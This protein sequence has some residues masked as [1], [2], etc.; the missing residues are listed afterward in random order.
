MGNS[1]SQNTNSSNNNL[2]EFILK[3]DTY[4]ANYITNQ[5]VTSSTR[6][7]DLNYCDDLIIMTSNTLAEKLSS[8]E[9]DYLAQRT[10]K[11]N[12]INSMES[13]KI[14]YLNKKDLNDLDVQNKTKKRRLCIGIARFYVKIGQLYSAIL[15]TINPVYSYIDSNNKQI[16]YTL[17]DKRKKKMSPNLVYHSTQ[18]NF[19]NNRI[20]TLLNGEDFSEE[21]EQNNQDVTVNP[22]I[23]R[24]NY[25]DGRSTKFLEQIGMVEFEKLFFD[26]YNYDLGI[27]DKMSD[28]MKVDYK[29]ALTEFYKA[30]T[31]DTNKMPDNIKQ[32]KDIPL[33]AFHD[34]PNCKEEN[35][36]YKQKYK[37]KLTDQLFKKYALHLKEMYN[38][39]QK[40]N[41]ELLEILKKV[42]SIIKNSSS[43][44]ESVIINPNLNYIELEK[45]IKEA[46]NT[47]LKLYTDCE[48]DFYKGFEILQE[49]V[50]NQ[51]NVQVQE[52]LTNLKKTSIFT[53]P[54]NNVVD[55]PY[56]EQPYVE[57]PY[58]EQPYVEQPYVEQPYIEEK[59]YIENNYYKDSNNLNYRNLYE[60]KRKELDNLKFQKAY[61]ESKKEI[62]DLKKQLPVLNS[63]KNNLL[64]VPPSRMTV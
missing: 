52:Q 13:D 5:D 34:Y 32:F 61:I 26:V 46:Q 8:I 48:K 22:D 24:V 16:Y 62:D 33:R 25:K 3:I 20:N 31:G 53:N 44:I 7:A 57:Q 1:Q 11:G 49:I 17:N 54:Q 40:K 23:C 15:K 55:Q 29:T 50:V 18:I 56:V 64:N 4:A 37:G 6:M 19:C 14:I 9:I 63:D 30:Y 60:E 38:K 36:L 45:I 10:E 27:F 47:I 21:K 43:G 51:K 35:G 58:V 41:D 59:S 39:T 2:L 12:I 28:K 42:F